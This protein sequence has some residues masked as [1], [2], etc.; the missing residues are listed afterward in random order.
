MN[1]PVDPALLKLVQHHVSALKTDVDKMSFEMEDDRKEVKKALQDVNAHLDELEKRVS[2]VEQGVKHLEIQQSS[3]KENVD[4]L[5]QR[6]VQV[7]ER[8]SS[9]THQISWGKIN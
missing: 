6:V 4:D 9:V 7:E 5:Q 1:T 2:M 8:M 3:M